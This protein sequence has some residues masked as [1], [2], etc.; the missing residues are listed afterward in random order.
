[1]EGHGHG[2]L[3]GGRLRLAGMMEFRPVDAPLDPRRITAMK[4]AVAPLLRGIDL[5]D[6][7]D[8]WVGARPRTAHGLPL[9][10]R[11]R[12]PRVFVAGGHGMWGMTLGPVTGKLVAAQVAT[13]ETPTA[14]R[15]LDPLR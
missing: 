5:E 12:D 13:G 2:L 14:L 9:V 1:M 4:D 6:R 11:S 3:V 8:E 10:G 7:Q 15:A